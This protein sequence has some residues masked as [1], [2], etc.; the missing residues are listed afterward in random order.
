MAN[1]IFFGI[2]FILF[3]LNIDLTLAQE[4]PIFTISNGE[5]SALL[6]GSNHLGK[7]PVIGSKEFDFRLSSSQAI[8]FEYD[9]NDKEAVKKTKEFVLKNSKGNSLDKRFSELTLSKIEAKFAQFAVDRNMI[10]AMSPMT[11]YVYLEKMDKRLNRMNSNLKVTNSIDWYIK[12]L[13][14]KNNI[15]TAGLE[16]TYAV[17]SSI[18]QISDSDWEEFINRFISMLDCSECVDNYIGNMEKA[19]MPSKDPNHVY[20]YL[21]ESFSSDPKLG[22]LYEHFL[23]SRRNVEMAERIDIDVLKA[24]KCDVVVIGA[25][26]LGGDKGILANLK[27][28]G[29][30][31]SDF[32]VTETV[33]K[34]AENSN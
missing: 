7:I 28:K 20:K 26:H 30:S 12:N 16:S 5:N 17:A 34:N 24:N 4:Y 29:I 15:L 31:V 9:A 32:S 33:H 2:F 21:M 27:K 14:L 19:Y 13:A 6:I 10:Y 8:C 11:L 22:S 18:S 1:R 23:L 3:G 25:A